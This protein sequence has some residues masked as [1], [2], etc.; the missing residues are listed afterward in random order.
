M[1]RGATKSI[2]FSSRFDRGIKLHR[3]A[4][5]FLRSEALRGRSRFF[6]V[7]GVVWML[8]D[9][10]ILIGWLS[11]TPTSFHCGDAWNPPNRWISFERQRIVVEEPHD[12]GAIEPRSHSFRRRI[13]PTGSDGGRLSSRITIDTR[14]WPDR[15]AIVA[16]FEADLRLMDR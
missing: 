2:Q 8:S 9:R 13:D 4:V 15:G 6:A 11:I 5:I 12:H 7:G 10:T 16:K 3:N 14:S 1:T